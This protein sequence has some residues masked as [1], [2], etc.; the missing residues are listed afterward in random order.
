[1]DFAYVDS[2]ERGQVMQITKTGE[3]GNVYFATP[4]LNLTSWTKDA[5]LV[6]DIKME[7]VTKGDKIMV[8]VDSGWP[9][10][11]D[12]PIDVPQD[13][14]WHTVT[15]SLNDLVQNGNSFASGKVDMSKIK[16]LLVLDPQGEMIFQLDNV[17][18]ER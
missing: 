11:S 9:N 18:F 1:M 7:E 14:Q 10:V 6:F 13:N 2:G 17:R 3:T 8:K 4:E 5:K 12:Y 15:I 16:N